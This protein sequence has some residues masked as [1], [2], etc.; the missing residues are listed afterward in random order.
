MLTTLRAN[1]NLAVFLISIVLM[2]VAHGIEAMAL[3]PL[4]LTEVLGSSVTLV[5]AVISTYL[6]VDIV[7]R[8]PAG[9][10]ADRWGRKAILVGG[11]ALSIVPLPLMMRVQDARVFL[12]L[13]AVNGLGAGCIWPAIYAG[14]ADTYRRSHRGL[15]MGIL[16]TVMLGGLALGPISGNLLLGFTS[17]QTTF[18]ACVALV[19]AALLL[20]LFLVKETAAE[21]EEESR[22][23]AMDV[24]RQL[25]R[26]LALLGMVALLLTVSLAL[27]LPIISLYGAEILLVDKVTMGVLLA[28]PGG[29]TA[30][31]LLPAGHLADRL[32]RKPLI[33]VGLALL[34]ACYAA[35]PTTINLVVVAAGATLAGLGYALA[36][37]AW[38]ALAMDT[39]PQKSRGL[40]LGAVASVQGAG[41]AIGPVVGGYLWEQIHP[42]APFTVGACLL[43]AATLLSLWISP[44]R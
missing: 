19:C 13:N 4:Y 42:Y 27:L 5:G 25:T 8:T 6:I 26:E 28:V 20:V 30:L 33:V 1:R 36:V 38:N 17:Y 31:V 44:R 39:I 35:A 21:H 11:I 32:G 12:L 29:I 15:I 43:F 16:S 24:L 10:L 9:W 22:T 14:V 40:L 41:L 7:T 2:E 37:P 18:L 3:F 34:T 23:A